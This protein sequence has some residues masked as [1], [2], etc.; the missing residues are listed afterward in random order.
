MPKKYIR[1][2]S[3]LNQNHVPK[4]QL[5]SCASATAHPVPWL[6]LTLVLPLQYVK[7]H[8]GASNNVYGPQFGQG[9][10]LRCPILLLSV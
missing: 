8:S 10:P 2:E 6:I 3:E 4:I 7:Q 9:P 5:V 1:R